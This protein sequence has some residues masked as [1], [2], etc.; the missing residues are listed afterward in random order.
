MGGSLASDFGKDE[1]AAD[2]DALMTE[3]AFA[4]YIL[5][6][7]ARGYYS[8]LEQ[9]LIA[10]KQLRSVASTVTGSCLVFLACAV[11]GYAGND[12]TVLYL[13]TLVFYL[14]RIVGAICVLGKL[15]RV[16]GMERFKTDT[17]S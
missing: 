9:A 13:G 6:I 15:M 2:L 11:T 3:G 4:I 16:H 12:F 10:A 14:C 8:M 5:V 17:R 1:E 7:L